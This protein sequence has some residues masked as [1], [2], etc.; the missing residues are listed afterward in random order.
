[1]TQYPFLRGQNID[2][3]QLRVQGSILEKWASVAAIRIFSRQRVNTDV[4]LK[5]SFLGGV[6]TVTGSKY[7]VEHEESRILV[8]CGLFQGFK[9]LRFK[10]WAPYPLEPRSIG[11]VIL[12]HAH[13]DHSG[14]LPLLVKHGFKGPIYCSQATS[15][16]CRILLPDCGH[17]QE[18]DAEFANRHGF[19]KHH[20]ALPLYTEQDARTALKQLSPIR[21]DQDER[22]LS[23]ATVRL[24]RTGHILGAASVNWTGPASRPSSGDLGRHDD[25]PWSIRSR[26]IRLTICWSIDLLEP[27]P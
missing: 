20:P 2:A 6:E 14:Y 21:L 9:A 23:D 4:T 26:S 16:L 24:R 7:S 19:S 5:L 18:K 17:L 13:L 8:D 12:T 1:M 11:A 25:A 15:D 22:V 27:Q 3:N 10:N